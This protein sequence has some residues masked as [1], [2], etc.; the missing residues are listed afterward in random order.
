MRVNRWWLIFYILKKLRRMKIQFN[1]KYPIASLEMVIG[2][3]LHQ[4]LLLQG[5]INADA[6]PPGSARLR[7]TWADMQIWNGS[8]QSGAHANDTTRPMNLQPDRL[9]AK[10]HLRWQW[11]H[12][13]VRQSKRIE[14]T[15]KQPNCIC[16]EMS[17]QIKSP[18]VADD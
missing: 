3:S 12:C 2:K 5:A 6:S 13:I 7:L 11:L 1:N 16:D 8:S 10:A 15:S 9:V 18:S 14:S 4:Q 17:L